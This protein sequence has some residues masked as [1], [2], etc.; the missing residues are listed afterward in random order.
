MAKRVIWTR[1]LAYCLS[2]NFNMNT[3]MSKNQFNPTIFKE[4]ESLRQQVLQRTIQNSSYTTCI[5]QI[6]TEYTLLCLDLFSELD[7]LINSNMTSYYSYRLEGKLI[8]IVSLW[9]LLPKLG[10]ELNPEPM[11][12]V[13]VMGMSTYYDSNEAIDAWK[14]LPV[15]YRLEIINTLVL[16]LKKSGETNQL[17]DMTLLRLFHESEIHQ[18]NI[19][20]AIFKSF[21]LPTNPELLVNAPIKDIVVKLAQTERD[22]GY[23]I[24][25]ILA[26][27][28]E[29][30]ADVRAI[31]AELLNRLSNKLPIAHQN[32]VITAL[33][34]VINEQN[35]RCNPI[36]AVSALLKLG[37]YEA[38]QEDIIN[39]LLVVLNNKKYPQNDRAHAAELL[40][41]LSITYQHKEV[42]KS[43]AMALQDT[44]CWK[45]IRI[46]AAESL[47]HLGLENTYSHDIVEVLITAAKKE[48]FSLDYN[49]DNLF[50]NSAINT[51]G[52]LAVADRTDVIH[53]LISRLNY[54]SF[55]Y[56]STSKTILNSAKKTLIILG[57][58]KTHKKNIVTTLI[59][60]LEDCKRDTVA[61]AVHA[62][63]ILAKLFSHTT[64]EK[65]SRLINA[66]ITLFKKSS[67][68]E[69]SEFRA[70]AANVLAEL[71]ENMAYREDVTNA[72][73]EAVEHR[74]WR[75]R[76]HAIN[77]LAKLPNAHCDPIIGLIINAL[78]DPHAEVSD[79]AT[80]ALI[81]VSQNNPDQDEAITTLIGMLKHS[82]PIIS[83]SVA[84]AFAHLAV[85]RRDDVIKA[86]LKMIQEEEW[87][88]RANAAETLGKISTHHQE[89]VIKALAIALNDE[90]LLV[91]FRAAE[92]L[93]QLGKNEPYQEE[94][95]T[96]FLRKMGSEISRFEFSNI[97]NTL[98]KFP[99]AHR[100]DV[101][102]N[103]FE[104][105]SNNSRRTAFRVIIEQALTSI[106]LIQKEIHPDD[107]GVNLLLKS[108]KMNGH[109]RTW[110]IKLFNRFNQDKI[111]Y[112]KL[113]NTL[114]AI[115]KDPKAIHRDS[116]VDALSQFPVV[117]KDNIIHALVNGLEDPDLTFRVSSAKALTRLHQDKPYHNTILSILLINFRKG[118]AFV[119]ASIIE[120]LTHIIERI[121]MDNAMIQSPLKLLLYQ[122][123]K[124][125]KYIKTEENVSHY[126][127]PAP[128]YQMT[129]DCYSDSEMTALLQYYIGDHPKVVY[130]DSMLKTNWRT[131]P[132][133]LII[134]TLN[135]CYREHERNKKKNR[136]TKNTIILP[137]NLGNSY[138]IIIYANYVDSKEELPFVS[139]FNPKSDPQ[140]QDLEKI[141]SCSDIFSEYVI[142]ERNYSKPPI[143]DHL[144]NCMPWVIE[145]SRRIANHDILPTRKDKID[146]A[147]LEH[148]NVLNGI[149]YP[150]KKNANISELS[151]FSMK[152]GSFQAKKSSPDPSSNQPSSSHFGSVV[153]FY[154]SLTF[155]SSLPT[156]TSLETSSEEYSK[157]FDDKGKEPAH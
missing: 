51:L 23:I 124:A 98:S 121:N 94:I 149:I 4:I 38:Y 61:T 80:D 95:T 3:K 55:Y 47:V 46:R 107:Y 18:Q 33:T 54:N 14:K 108:L 59:V 45:G 57:Q 56:D 143:Q 34:K 35:H 43:L 129:S 8:K 141:L 104:K 15:T 101:I 17:A 72:L 12:N 142:I 81:Q 151:F 133:K 147:R 156:S 29:P 140:H 116:A 28:R 106:Q 96:L 153:Q 119:D 118:S 30:I 31:A 152:D 105:F 89:E 49:N 6:A 122:F 117:Q 132:H 83:M 78:K 114:L 50:S 64:Q 44:S 126:Q 144:Y 112:E 113:I 63:Q 87:Y 139:Y 76:A 85:Q 58:D 131:R 84:K 66:F 52:K 93:I 97:I 130:L 92:A 157:I 82:N 48:K 154:R 13:V 115:V 128:V 109:V 24:K 39:T 150:S 1:A 9:L 41:T 19:I 155:H 7:V 69:Y 2:E 32:D 136:P 40:G 137:V 10:V 134:A 71:G 36:N 102:G 53:A 138:W 86:L 99:I 65:E 70:D 77:A 103:F 21:T 125:S 25:K 11:L 91:S 5:N 60:L 68:F 73:C 146:I 100:H 120:S 16:N 79:N 20:D 37:Q 62:A 110:A 88:V 42:I 145:A 135:A 26:L 22:Q 148:A 74:D 90:Q 27:I 127:I 67:H 123:E 75:V 111:Q